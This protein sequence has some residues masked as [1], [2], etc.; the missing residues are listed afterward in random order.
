[1]YAKHVFFVWLTHTYIV[2]TPP[3]RENSDEIDNAWHDGSP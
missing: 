1:M 2:D 3:F